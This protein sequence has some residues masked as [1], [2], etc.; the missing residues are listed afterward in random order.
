MVDLKSDTLRGFIKEGSDARLAKSFTFKTSLKASAFKVYTPEELVGFGF[1]NGRN[2][3]T[4]KSDLI[5]YPG[6]VFAKRLIK[7]K[8]DLYVWRKKSQAKPDMFITNNEIDKT[9]HLINPSKKNVTS[10]DGKKFSRKDRKYLGLLYSIKT[11]QQDQNRKEVRYSEKKIYEDLLNYNLQFSEDYPVSEYEEKQVNR[12]E[13]VVGMPME[14]SV[15]GTQ[16]RVS[17]YRDKQR[18]ERSTNWSYIR[19]VSFRHW[20]NED[21]ELPDFKNGTSNYR[22]QTLSLIPIGVKYQKAKGIVR[23]YAYAGLGIGV[24]LMT[25]YVIEKYENTGSEK[26]FSYGPTANLGVG[27]KINLG[28]SYLLTEITPTIDGIFFNGITPPMDALFL[29][30]GYS[31]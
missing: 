2:F 13:I 6:F 26:S 11:E 17:I 28:N 5:N 18:T 31:F 7:G 19:G 23:P 4:Q 25:N 21:R 14:N 24:L 9:V 22:W 3:K 8:T 10:E 15:G 12:Y 29:N 1:E 30:L 27:L 20:G 16:F